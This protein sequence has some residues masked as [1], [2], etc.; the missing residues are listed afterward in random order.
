[1]K[2]RKKSK[3]K[4]MMKL[5]CMS[6]KTKDYMRNLN[7]MSSTILTHPHTWVE[8]VCLQAFPFEIPLFYF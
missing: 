7:E 8:V 6:L 4:I 1:M 3:K 5:S 2:F